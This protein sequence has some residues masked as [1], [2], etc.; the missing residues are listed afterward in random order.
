MFP[1]ISNSRN[2]HPYWLDFAKEDLEA[3]GKVAAKYGA[4]ITMHPGQYDVVGCPDETI[5]QNTCTDLFY[6]AQVLDYM[7]VGPEGVIVIHGGGLY[8]DKESAIERW[9]KN[10]HRLP[11][12]VKRRLVIENDERCFPPRDCL[13]IS[14]K[15]NIPVVLDNHH[16]DCFMKAHLEEAHEHGDITDW[17]GPCLDTWIERRI[18]PKFHISEQRED[19]RLGTHS[20]F[21][22]TIPQ[23]YLEIPE[24][25]GVGIDIMV[26]AKAKEA[27]IMNLYEKYPHLRLN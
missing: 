16:Y 4:R 26:E 19:A 25:Y 1:H 5:F 14:K 12:A 9:C 6:H 11:E 13:I 15:V 24:K 10:F 7:G 2:P 22:E 8:G 20:D 17:I 3:A 18:R 23:Y 27:A 21:I